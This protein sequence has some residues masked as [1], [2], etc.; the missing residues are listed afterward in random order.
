M[1]CKCELVS[2]F[3][4]VS[5]LEKTKDGRVVDGRVGMFDDRGRHGAS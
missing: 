1:K 3:R 4:G 2:I 5:V